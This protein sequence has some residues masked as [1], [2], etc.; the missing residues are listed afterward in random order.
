M[1]KRI[2]V[3][4][5]DEEHQ[6]F[7]DAGTVCGHKQSTAFFRFLLRRVLCDIQAEL[8]GKRLCYRKGDEIELIAP[9]TPRPGDGAK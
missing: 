6:A 8:E 4:V 5:T 3:D 7:L 2:A 1:A 9:L